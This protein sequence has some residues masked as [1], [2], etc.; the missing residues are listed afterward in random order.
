MILFRLKHV[1]LVDEG[2]I[3]AGS[4]STRTDSL[5]QGKQIHFFLQLTS[6]MLLSN[7]YKKILLALAL[8][9]GMLSQSLPGLASGH[10]VSLIVTPIPGGGLSRVH[11]GRVRPARA[12]PLKAGARKAAAAKF[13]NSA[14]AKAAA[15]AARKARSRSALLS[16]GKKGKKA[17][18]T[19]TPSQL[20]Q[21][22]IM[23]LSQQTLAPGVVH[24]CHRGPLNINIIDT[25]LSNKNIEVKPVL[26]GNTLNVLD[27]VRDQAHKV[28]AIAAVNANYFKKDGTPLGT[29]VLDGE[30][31]AGPLYDRVSFG[32]TESGQCF[33]DRAN[34]H[35]TIET[36]NP[37]VS[38][39][40]VNNINQP[41]RSGCKLIAYTR[42]WGSEVKMAYAGCLVAVDS[43]GR[44]VDKTSQRIGVPYGG[45]VLSD[46]KASIINKL[47][48]GDLVFLEW[49]H[50][51][52]NWSDVIQAVSG[53]PALIKNG[54]LYV[55]LK[56]ENF[57]KA[58]TSSSIHARTALGV[59]KNHHLILATVEGPHT[60]WDLAKMLQKMGCVEA[61]NLDG[62]GS[63]TMVVRGNIVTRNKN[64]FQRRVA[65]SLAVLPRSQELSISRRLFGSY[66]PVTDL[67]APLADDLLNEFS[68]LQVP[69]ADPVANEIEHN[70]LAAPQRLSADL[71]KESE[72]AARKEQAVSSASVISR[73]EAK[74][75]R[76]A[77]SSDRSLAGSLGKPFGFGW[78]K[79]LLGK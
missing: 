59:T 48:R 74:K 54:K 45:F 47:K 64:T 79:S 55:D 11:T 26:A 13:K 35:G 63:T 78:M 77:R 46:K 68:L 12:V 25:D 4:G 52:Q 7:G 65:A 37:E 34:L 22:G 40:W 67:S 5:H 1:S 49:H 66:V 57:R 36:S 75:T 24:K 39:L 50:R 44:V 3:N 6:E 21:D 76:Q 71:L 60:L 31:V 58:W 53:G 18:A 73:S 41:R 19:P 62:G 33:V 32:L 29:L 42:R 9:T 14:K 28:N 20:P 70:L 38:S 2:G 69:V 61:M 15:L 8:S 16:A 27:E 43:G 10:A 23:S 30:W 72:E 56:D 51:P 17:K